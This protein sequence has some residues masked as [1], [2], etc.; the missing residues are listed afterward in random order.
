M[1]KY[2]NCSY[3]KSVFF[4]CAGKYVCVSFFAVE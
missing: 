1:N 3:L 4:T 2:T